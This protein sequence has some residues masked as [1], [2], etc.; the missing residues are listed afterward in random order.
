MT[1]RTPIKKA[2]VRKEKIAVIHVCTEKEQINR[3]SQILVGNGNPEEGY[4]YKV[5]AMGKQ[6]SEINDRITGI[7]AVVN[8]LHEA[9]VGVKAVEKSTQDKRKEI[10]KMTS[11]IVGTICLILTAYFSYKGIKVSEMNTIKINDLGIPVIVN[12]RGEIGRLPEGDSLKY[13]KNGEFN[14]YEDR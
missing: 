8:E 5:M 7:H 14:N 6:V 13:F 1:Q 10:I 2:T 11:F 9:S 3:L 12:Q 4:V